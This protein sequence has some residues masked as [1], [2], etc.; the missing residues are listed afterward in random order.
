MESESL[1]CT[2]RLVSNTRRTVS[3][4]LKEKDFAAH[5]ALT[6]RT[7]AL[8]VKDLNAAPLILGYR[9]ITNT[10][11]ILMIVK[12]KHELMKAWYKTRRELIGFL[13]AST[14]IILFVILAGSL[15]SQV[16][17]AD[18]IV[19]DMNRFAHSVDESVA[20][21]ELGEAPGS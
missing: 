15:I 1:L 2:S 20:K 10:P 11:F 18:G 16:R 21:V 12:Q 4:F 7:W 3:F 6:P 8:E 19:E 13:F 9:Y 14:T 17:R 5:S